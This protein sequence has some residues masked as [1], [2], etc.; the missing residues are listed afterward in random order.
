MAVIGSIRKRTG[1][2]IGFIAIALLMF[3]LMDALSS[4][5]MIGGGGSGQTVGKIDG[6]K[7]DYMAY[8]MELTEYEERI[9]TL[10]PQAEVNAANRAQFRDEVWNNFVSRAILGDLKNKMGINV[11][12]DEL[13]NAMWGDN[14]HFFAQNILVNPNTGQYDPNYARQVVIAAEENEQARTTVRHLEKLIEDDRMKTKYASLYSKG[15]YVP[16]FLAKDAKAKALM[17]ADASYIFFPYSEVADDQVTVTDRE[18]NDYIADNAAEF[19]QEATATIEYYTIDIVPS[20]QDSA[21]AEAAIAALVEEFEITSDDSLF[22]RRYSDIPFTGAYLTGDDLLGDPNAEALFADPVGTVYGPYL[23]G[24]SYKLAKL[25]DRKSIPDSVSARHILLTPTSFEQVDS[26]R[27]LADSLVDLLES[28]RASFDEL[29][30]VHS[31]DESNKSTGGDLGFFQQGMMVPPFNDAAFYQYE[32]GDIYTVDSRF[33]IH[34]V[35]IDEADPVIPAVRVAVVSQELEYSKETERE[36]FRA[37]NNFRSDYNTPE[38]FAEAESEYKISEENLQQN[39]VSMTGIE[40]ARDLVQWAFK[41]KVGAIQY[42]DIEDK[43]IIAHLTGKKEAGLA[44]LEDVRVQVEQEVKKEKKTAIIAEQVEAAGATD[45][46]QLASATG[47]EVNSLPSLSYSSI[48]IQG[49]GNDA[50]VVAH[51]FGMDQGEISPALS[52][53]NGAYVV[54]LNSITDPGADNNFFAEKA[55]LKPNVSYQSILESLKDEAKIEDTRYEFY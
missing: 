43:Y 3:L 29:A 51:I 46:N 2:L 22:I 40:D 9:T 21:D 38:K 12:P 13:G 19:E 41:E 14:P 11:T 36:L 54:Q 7:I 28:G 27:T 5:S 34:I 10:F 50:E 4:N 44:E 52:G 45:L 53:A 35:R 55:R 48:S 24:G 47:K 31:Q 1:L 20:A 37:A 33:G 25:K 30:L 6:K 23:E 17:T 26:M 42:F 32:E 8:Q 39:Q 16:D 18:L 15:M 49:S